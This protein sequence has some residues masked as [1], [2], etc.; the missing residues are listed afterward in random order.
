MSKALSFRAVL[1]LWMGGLALLCA[2]GLTLYFEFNAQ[3]QQAHQQGLALNVKARAAAELLTTNVR[4]RE[5]EIDLIRQLP[6]LTRGDL[7]SAKLKSFLELRQ[8][9]QNDYVWMGV[10]TL[11]GKVSQ[12][13]AGLLVGEDVSQRPWFAAALKGTYIGNVHDA[14]LLA[15]KLPKTSAS[16]PPKFIDIAAPIF[17][18]RGKLRGVFAA[19]A[20][21]SEINDEINAKLIRQ[22]GVEPVELFIT[23]TRGDLLYPLS[24]TSVI[25][26]PLELSDTV[27]YADQV[28]GDGVR[29]I[30]S[31]VMV[32]PSRSSDIRWRVVVRQTVH[33][34]GWL[35][36]I[37]SGRLFA[38]TGLAI[39]VFLLAAYILGT[40][41]QQSLKPLRH[42]MLHPRSAHGFP[43]EMKAVIGFE[44]VA[45]LE[46]A[47]DSMKSWFNVLLESLRDEKEKLLA[48]SQSSA[49][50]AHPL[51]G[52]AELTEQ[53]DR[54]T[55]FL[56]GQAFNARLRSVFSVLLRKWRPFT[57]LL[58]KVEGLHQIAL[59]RGVSQE[60]RA[61]RQVAEIIT[62]C[63][64]KNEVIAR[65]QDDVFAILLLDEDSAASGVRLCQEMQAWMRVQEP[66]E[67]VCPTVH[68]ATA[69]SVTLDAGAQD[70]M[71]RALR[72][73]NASVS[74]DSSNKGVSDGGA[75]GDSQLSESV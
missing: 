1:C 52:T 74:P 49:H 56:S 51:S 38:A 32:A 28:W 61:I 12:A 43:E 60:Q 30:S 4:S 45:Q 17:D 40:A 14:L 2:L 6:L 64:R 73:L 46:Q 59:E 65:Y 63:C 53:R 50:G 54:L 75:S 48:G 9:F 55:G 22:V 71:E 15:S 29:Y 13:T 44:E 36:I 66:D 72:D 25:Q 20:H 62:H 5:L 8:T 23:D 19:H 57:V 26:V 7:K 3:R 67:G 18:A 68:M 37:E 16:G 11:D 34:R 47:L 42:D 35:A 58:I 70:V 31:T 10:A 21:W 41:L 27:P 39:L 33:E 69:T 24:S